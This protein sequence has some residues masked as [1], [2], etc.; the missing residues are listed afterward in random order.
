VPGA[1]LLAC[2]KAVAIDGAVDRQ[3][4]LQVIEL[5]LQQFGKIIAGRHYQGPA[6]FSVVIHA[7]LE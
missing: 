3:H 1:P 6:I 7:H 5:V 4:S 2:A